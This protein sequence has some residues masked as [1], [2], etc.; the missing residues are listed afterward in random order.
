MKYMQRSNDYD[1]ES[2]NLSYIKGQWLRLNGVRDSK[3]I[4]SINKLQEP[5]ELNNV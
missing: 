3:K 5:V 4:G 1:D 2:C